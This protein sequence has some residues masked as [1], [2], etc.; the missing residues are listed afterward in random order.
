MSQEN[1]TIDITRFIKEELRLTANDA[2]VV[3]MDIDWEPWDIL[4]GTPPA[5]PSYTE[6]YTI[7]PGAK[8]NST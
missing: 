5:N 3:K 7:V 2:V 8:Y 6:Q 4:P 1:N